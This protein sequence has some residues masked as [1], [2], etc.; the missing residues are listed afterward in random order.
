[1]L[2]EVLPVMSSIISRAMTRVARGRCDE[3]RSA[4][5]AAN[6]RRVNECQS[7][8]EHGAAVYQTLNVFLRL[9]SVFLFV[10]LWEINCLI[11]PYTA[12]YQRIYLWLKLRVNL[13]HH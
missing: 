8:H 3:G 1:V 11:S 2:F 6:T 10:S 13:A 9:I 7:Q 12:F 4:D 5:S